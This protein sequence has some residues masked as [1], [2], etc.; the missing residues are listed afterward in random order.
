[1]KFQYITLG[2]QQTKYFTGESEALMFQTMLVLMH[3]MHWIKY[4]LYIQ[5]T[6]NVT[7]LLFAN[8]VSYSQRSNIIL[9]FEN[10]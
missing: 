10:G 3:L 8:I 2:T 6:L 4:I 1:M 7:I 5:I 9:S